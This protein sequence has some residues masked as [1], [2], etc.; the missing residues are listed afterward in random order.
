VDF[1]SMKFS[2]RR[3][4]RVSGWGMVAIIGILSLVPGVLRPHTGLPNQLEHFGAYL[5]TASTLV[6]A[7]SKGLSALRIGL[8]L[9]T[10][11]R[12]L[13]IAQLWVPGRSS[14]LIDFVAS[15]LGILAGCF[16]TVLVCRFNAKAKTSRIYD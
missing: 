12:L 2:A 16:F 11:A 9:G 14:R 15:F 5:V 8:Y 6:L 4:L 10:Y 13:E 3:V 1:E 7:S